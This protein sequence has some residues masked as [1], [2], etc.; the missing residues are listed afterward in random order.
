MIRRPPRST[1]TDTL[2]PYTTL[3]RSQD[4]AAMV[5]DILKWDDQPVSLTHFAESTVRGYRLATSAPNGPV[6]ITVDSHLQGAPLERAPALPTL[7]PQTPPVADHAALQPPAALDRAAAETGT[8]LVEDLKEA[9]V[10][11]T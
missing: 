9:V 2:F 7:S 8:R 1:R 5:R 6:M 11:S 4:N 10:S 3:F